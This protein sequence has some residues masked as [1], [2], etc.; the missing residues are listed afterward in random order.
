MTHSKDLSALFDDAF[1]LYTVWYTGRHR[2]LTQDMVS[3]LSERFSDLG[4]LVIQDGDDD[5]IGQS[6]ANSADGLRRRNDQF[7]P[8]VEDQG[9]VDVV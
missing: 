5:S 2:F 8:C 1:H 4:M 7:L 3:L 6:F 9:L